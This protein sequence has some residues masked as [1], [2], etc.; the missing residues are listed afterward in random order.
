M[1]GPEL[2]LVGREAAE[3]ADVATA[4]AV[5]HPVLRGGRAAAASA[6]AATTATAGVDGGA[7]GGEVGEAIV[8]ADV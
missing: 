8:H 5:G 4:G 2:V 1:L 7:R 3:H 6:A